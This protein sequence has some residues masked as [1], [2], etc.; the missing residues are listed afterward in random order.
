MDERI[1]RNNETINLGNDRLARPGKSPVG[2]ILFQECTEGG[3]TL[4][5]QVSGRR[6]GSYIW[7]DIICITN[8]WIKC[9]IRGAFSNC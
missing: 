5:Y 7:T 6:S 3:R 1:V 8:Q 2:G 4:W 9:S